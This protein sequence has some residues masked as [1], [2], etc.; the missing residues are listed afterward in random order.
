[1]VFITYEK[2]AEDKARVLLQVFKESAVSE[3]IKMTG[4]Y[5][6]AIPDPDPT[7]GIPI[8]LVNPITK[9][10]WYEYQPLPNTP[11]YPDTE[12]GSLQKQVDDLKLLLA[13]LVTGGAV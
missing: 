4:I 3:E 7:M 13:E 5:V 11:F 6:D 2:F 12:V 9:E 1:M 8:L 10:L